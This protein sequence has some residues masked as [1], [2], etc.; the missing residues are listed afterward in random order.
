MSFLDTAI[1]DNSLF[2]DVKLASDKV[3]G[4][5]TGLDGCNSREP[6]KEIADESKLSKEKEKVITNLI[7]NLIKV[8][9]N[10]VCV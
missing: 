3:G 8:V 9:E 4:I 2:I 5:L 6:E 1:A 10:I 7:L